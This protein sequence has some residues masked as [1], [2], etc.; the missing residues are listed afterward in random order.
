MPGMGGVK[1]LEKIIGINPEAKVVVASGYSANEA[2]KTV[3]KNWAKG[4][5]AKPY[6]ISQMLDVVRDVMEGR[7]QQ[8]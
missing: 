7:E 2:E 5:V 8:G 3:I 4:F 6:K 1:C